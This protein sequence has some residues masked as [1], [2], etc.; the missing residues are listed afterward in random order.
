MWLRKGSHKLRRYLPTS[1]KKEQGN[2]M[3]RASKTLTLDGITADKD[4]YIRIDK[5]NNTQG[6]MTILYTNVRQ[7]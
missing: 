5:L 4:Y 3:P 7:Q 6:E 1:A 2:V